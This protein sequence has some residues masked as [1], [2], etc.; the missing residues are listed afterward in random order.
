M[1]R[2]QH[3]FAHA[4]WCRAIC[5]CVVVCA[6]SSCATVKVRVLADPDHA[7]G[8]ATEIKDGGAAGAK[9]L[10][11]SGSVLKLKDHPATSGY[12]FRAE[13]EGFQ[14]GTAQLTLA[15]IKALP[16]DTRGV[17]VV[18]LDLT[19]EF[20][21]QWQ[22]VIVY[23]SVRGEFV[24][25]P[26]QVRAWRRTT[27]DDKGSVSRVFDRLEKDAGIRGLALSPD[28]RKL[29]FAE[30]LAIGDD[31]GAVRPQAN[32]IIKLKSCNL[33]AIGIDFLSA[34][35]DPRSGGIAL[36]RSGDYRDVDPAF[37]PDGREIIF[38]S[39]RRRSFSADLLQMSALG[40][41]GGIRDIYR[42]PGRGTALSPSMGADGTIVFAI[43]DASGG[44]TQIWTVGGGRFPTEIIDGSQ[45]RVS[46]DGSRIV[47]IGTDA[48]LWVVFSDGTEP[49]Q[50][51]FKA[52]ELTD[53]YYDALSL[54][55]QT[56]F[57]PTLF[58]PY[59]FP[60]WTPDGR[61]IVYTSLDGVDSTDRLNDD[62]WIIDAN[63]TNSVS[64]TSNGS[65]DSN[66]VV[67]P[68]G[69]WIFFVSNRGSEWAIWA[70]ETGGLS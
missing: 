17:R 64:I 63:G 59:S 5:A 43:H 51:T 68:D 16:T 26:R 67:S 61:R 38:A 2:K 24:G 53:T 19:N 70:I 58:P 36:L 15:E 37:T 3:E 28:G 11:A 40:R 69:K 32:N 7:T 12:V 27:G 23:D 39:N 56:T 10:F 13:A 1:N 48:N 4:T 49:T 62:I 21:L 6:M 44:N 8:T 20:V 25:R 9:Y 29:V 52:Q 35:G 34:T 66:P 50:L 65:I 42:V 60:R 22:I 31:T 54:V 41:S 55:E 47:Y 57:D 45:P 46:P 14:P 30:A 33:K 18:E